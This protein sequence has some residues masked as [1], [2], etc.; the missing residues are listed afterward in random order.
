MLPN[1]FC[2]RCVGNVY[3]VQQNPNSSGTVF[4][5]DRSVLD[6]RFCKIEEADPTS[7]STCSARELW[8]LTPLEAA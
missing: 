7:V 8:N 3:F 2:G 5:F 4:Y 1:V 6:E